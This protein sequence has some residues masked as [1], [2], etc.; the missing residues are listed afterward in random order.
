MSNN[1]PI[2]FT[3][4]SHADQRYGRNI[5]FLFNPNDSHIFRNIG[6]RDATF[7]FL[8]SVAQFNSNSSSMISLKQMVLRRSR[9]FII[10]QNEMV[11][12][13]NNKFELHSEN[14]SASLA[15]DL[16]VQSESPKFYGGTVNVYLMYHPPSVTILPLEKYYYVG[17]DSFFLRMFREKYQLNAYSCTN[18]LA[19]SL[20]D[21]F[22]NL[23]RFA[24]IKTFHRNMYVSNEVT[25]FNK[26]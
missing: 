26:R 10:M 22:F 18:I 8:S 24:A 2:M 6:S 4:T 9:S 11:S 15:A 1:V 20:G 14:I 5:N 12:M 16:A 7:I 3:P 17:G 19:T 13:E 25:E 21:L 23:K